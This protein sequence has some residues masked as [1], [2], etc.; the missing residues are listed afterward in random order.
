MNVLRDLKAYAL[1]VAIGLAMGQD[2]NTLEHEHNPLQRD[3][4]QIFNHLAR[5]LTSPF[6]Y[7]R[8][9]RMPA[10]RAADA[11][12]ARIAETVRGFISQTRKRLQA[13]PERRAK[14]ANLLEALVLARDEI[15][16]EF[17]D[18]V[19]IGNAI[20]MVFAGEDTTSNTITWLLNFIARDP[21]VAA[22]LA[23]EAD[24]VLGDAKVLRAY[25]ALDQFP[26][27]EA[28]T[29]KAMRLKPVAPF[30]GLETNR[31]L[32]IGGTL[33]PQGTL[34]LAVLRTAGQQ[35][36]DFPQADQFRPECWLADTAMRDNDDPA[37][38]LF[39]FGA[40]PRFCPGRFLAMAEIKMV[41]SMVTRNFMLSVPSDAPEVK[42]HFTFTMTPSHLPVLLKVRGEK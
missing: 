4:E 18:A 30:L 29:S 25:G 35:E 34:V 20:T 9:L 1:D 19:V 32:V 8:H 26:Y 17:S 10:D 21:R 15:G 42:E 14:P 3:I 5:R 40:G 31:E 36:T 28:A 2:I 38:K 22:L 16:S 13:H 33:V 24:A 41:M 7:G 11:G 12:V 37:R 39:P 23:A 27:A 6:P